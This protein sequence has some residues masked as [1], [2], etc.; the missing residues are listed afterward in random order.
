MRTLWNDLRLPSIGF[1]FQEENASCFKATASWQ[2]SENQE[3]EDGED[4]WRRDRINLCTRESSFLWKN[5]S[6]ELILTAVD[7]EDQSGSALKKKIKNTNTRS[8]NVS[9][10][11]F[12]TRE[13]VGSANSGT[14]KCWGLTVLQN[15]RFLE[16][17]WQT[18]SVGESSSIQFNFNKI[19]IVKVI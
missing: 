14:A 8:A 4:Y 2:D 17:L 18:I 13:Y 12:M 5:S 15:W 11:H 6:A 3:R 16:V 1:A 10:S 9:M 7:M 19:K